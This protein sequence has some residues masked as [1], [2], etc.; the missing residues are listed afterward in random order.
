MKQI[1]GSASTSNVLPPVRARSWQPGTYVCSALDLLALGKQLQYT[2]EGLHEAR[3]SC[4]LQTFTIHGIPPCTRMAWLIDPLTSTPDRRKPPPAQRLALTTSRQ[5]TREHKRL[6]PQGSRMTAQHAVAKG[7]PSIPGLGCA[8]GL[9]GTHA[10]ES[11]LQRRQH[12]R[13]HH[14]QDV[15]RR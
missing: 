13:Y 3:E 15:P 6:T 1:A 11:S 14:C 12:D 8:S 2:A 9:A 5:T 7:Q 10:G 4:K